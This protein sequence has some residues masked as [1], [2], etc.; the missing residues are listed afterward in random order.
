M[1]ADQVVTAFCEA[2][3]KGSIDEVMQYV[4]DDCEY[5][6]IPLEPIRGAAAI[7]KALEGFG[8]MLGSIRFEVLHQV[9]SGGVVMNER[10]DH[11]SPP[12]RPRYGLPVTGVFEVRDGKI[13]AWRDYFDVGQFQRGTG[14][15]L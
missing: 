10:V 1:N 15:E 7:R 9:G 5:H 14:I 3:E 12:N 6:N 4:D 2:F 8:Q 13:V 11:F